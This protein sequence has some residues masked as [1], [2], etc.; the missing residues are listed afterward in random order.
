MRN[1][2]YGHDDFVI[3]TLLKGKFPY[4]GVSFQHDIF[5]MKLK[6][7]TVT[8]HLN[9]VKPRAFFSI[10]LWASAGRIFILQMYRLRI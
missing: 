1:Y 6:Q 5:I 10:S 3:N 7:D 8:K 4:T 2:T 9:C